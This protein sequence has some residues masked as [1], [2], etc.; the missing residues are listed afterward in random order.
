MTD[1]GSSNNIS[2]N[3]QDDKT[4]GMVFVNKDGKLTSKEI[5]CYDCGGNHYKGDPDCPK[6]QSKLNDGD[7]YSGVSNTLTVAFIGTHPC[8]NIIKKDWILLDNQSS[9]HIFKSKAMVTNITTVSDDKDLTMHS[10]GGSQYTN[11]IATHPDIGTVWF[12]PNEITNIISFSQCCCDGM[13]LAYNY[14]TDHF[15]LQKM[16]GK[17]LYFRHMVE[18]LYACNSSRPIVLCAATVE[19]QQWMFMPRQIT[20]AEKACSLQHMLSQP[21]DHTLKHMLQHKLIHN[22]PV[23]AEDVDRA[24]KARSVRATTLQQLYNN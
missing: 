24:N 18:G 7:G 23:T 6:H 19:E 10:N 12:N 9:V 17:V 13:H 21:S 5:I 16:N 15:K 14:D 20:A 4:H 3:K 11:Q 22:T 1:G 2:N 8:N